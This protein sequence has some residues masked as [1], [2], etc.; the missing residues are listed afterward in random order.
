MNTDQILSVKGVPLPS[1]PVLF[2]E[3]TADA[4]LASARSLA[5]RLDEFGVNIQ[6]GNILDIGCGY[7]RIAYGLL[8]RGYSGNYTGVD[9]INTRIDWL[10]EH[11]TP[12]CGNY[13]FHHIDVVNE[14]YNPKGRLNSTDIE[15]T[16][17]VGEQPL[18]SI[19][20]LSVFTHMYEPE[21]TAYLHQLFRV[22]GP[23]TRVIITM[24]LYTDAR[25]ASLDRNAKFRFAQVIDKNCRCE[26]ADNPLQAIAYQ[27]DK[28]RQLFEAAGFSIEIAHGSWNGDQAPHLQD[29]I[30]ARRIV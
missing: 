4:A 22:T 20:L 30:T 18:D 11:F 12:D 13:A 29:W 28:A 3:T 8:E 5:K 23:E 25:L 16:G 19:I 2:M 17:F 27:E 14:H 26:R 6:D 1:R 21:L 24:F 15:F 10:R 9:I 7:G